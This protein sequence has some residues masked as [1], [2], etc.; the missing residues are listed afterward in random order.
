MWYH[1][2]LDHHQSKRHRTLKK[3]YPW[4]KIPCYLCLSLFLF[5]N[6]VTGTAADKPRIVLLPF[7]IVSSEQVDLVQKGIE[8]FLISRLSGG[9]CGFSIH[10]EKPVEQIRTPEDCAA[11]C[12]N[13]SCNFLIYGSLVK[14]GDTVSTDVFVYDAAQGKIIL[15]FTDIGQ[16]DGAYLSHL[17]SFTKKTRNILSSPCYPLEESV[18]PP[19][20]T[21]KPLTERITKSQEFKGVVNGIAVADFDQDGQIDIATATDQSITIYSLIRK[22][23]EEKVTITVPIRG[24]VVGVDSANINGNAYPEIYVSVVTEDRMDISSLVIE[25]DG[26]AYKTIR[27][28]LKWLFRSMTLKGENKPVIIAQKNK[29]LGSILGSPIVRFAF[30]TPDSALK[31]M[32]VPEG[33]LLYSFALTQDSTSALADMKDNKI[34]VFDDARNLKWESDDVLGG[35]VSYMARPDTADRDKI[36]RVYLQPRIIFSD[37]DKDGADELIAIQNKEATNHL[38]AGMK[39][40]TKG[41]IT[42]FTPGDFGYSPVHSTDWISGYISDVTLVDMDGD[43]VPELVYSLISKGG[44][45]SDRRSSIVIH[46]MTEWYD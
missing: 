23:F 13:L 8:T 17:N 16:G 7:H 30:N 6:P 22:T 32:D 20:K 18:L 33:T 2:D 31:I 11:L 27:S 28:D 26:R 41:R 3:K 14:L 46:R 36:N 44:V 1:Y 9:D 15:H 40:F 25:W 38:F 5:L 34:R 35:T 21:S 29:N 45:F 24:Y 4:I 37:L 19:K 43:S 39:N 12:K 10:S 42:L